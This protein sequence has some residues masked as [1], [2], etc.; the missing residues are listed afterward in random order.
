MS[1]I[2]EIFVLKMKDPERAAAVREAARADFLGL[3]GV[4]S[5]RTFVTINPDKPTLFA[6]IYRF[7]DEQTA[8]RV[9][10]EFAKR[11]ATVAFLDEIEEILVGQ[12]F[13]EV[14]GEKTKGGT[15]E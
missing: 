11:P 14:L 15:E 2:T 1:E 10:P 6:E 12:Y 9:T 13:V 4:E 8:R 3:E 5:W 7:P